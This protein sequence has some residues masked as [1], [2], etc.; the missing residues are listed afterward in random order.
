M[1]THPTESAEDSHANEVRPE[2]RYFES[3]CRI[4][5][6]SMNIGQDDDR[7]AKDAQRN[8]DLDNGRSWTS[9][10]AGSTWV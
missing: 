2:A 10:L 3:S 8:W 9:P 6:G 7:L 5:M 4:A 1:M